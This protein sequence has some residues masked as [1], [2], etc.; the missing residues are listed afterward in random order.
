MKQSLPVSK[1][2]FNEKT[3]YC[4]ECGEELNDY[5]FNEKVDNLESIREHHQNCKKTKKFKGDQCSKL[6]IAEQIDPAEL[7]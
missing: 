4:T 5:C 7:E 2:G 3:K 1:K 6:F